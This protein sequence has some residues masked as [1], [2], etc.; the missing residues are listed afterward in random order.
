MI[1]NL[2]NDV[3]NIET[4]DNVTFNFFLWNA[5]TSN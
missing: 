2:D 5:L 1:F 4:P 3:R